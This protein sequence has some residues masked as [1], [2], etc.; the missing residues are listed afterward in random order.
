LKLPTRNSEVFGQPSFQ[1]P[2][3]QVGFLAAEAATHALYAFHYTAPHHGTAR[4]P[5]L[6]LAAPKPFPL[7]LGFAPPRLAAPRRPRRS[8]GVVAPAQGGQPLQSHR[9]KHPTSILR[10]A[11]T[12]Q[13]ETIRFPANLPAPWSGSTRF[14]TLEIRATAGECL[15]A[16]VLLVLAVSS[17]SQAML[18]ALRSCLSWMTESLYRTA[19]GC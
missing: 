16:G 12:P 10:S 11:P 13:I 19:V 9:R 5:T 1:R 17:G 4:Q 14:A 15:D 3:R 7:V 2:N 18:A 6:H 8:H